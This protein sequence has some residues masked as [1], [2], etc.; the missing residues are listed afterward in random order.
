MNFKPGFHK[1]AMEYVKHCSPA[2]L[3]HNHPPPTY[4]DIE[5][6]DIGDWDARENE[7]IDDMLDNVINTFGISRGELFME[8]KCIARYLAHTALHGWDE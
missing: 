5:K 6:N 1:A 2:T 3:L 4:W 8:A 7:L